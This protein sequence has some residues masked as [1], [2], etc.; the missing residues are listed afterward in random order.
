[1]AA[2]DYLYQFCDFYFSF[3]VVE[4]TVGHQSWQPDFLFEQT[5]F[6][7][8]SQKLPTTE[9]DYWTLKCDKLHEFDLVDE[10]KRKRVC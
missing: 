8:N 2:S 9:G 1:M 5:I 6:S 4:I 7:W 3:A 10:M